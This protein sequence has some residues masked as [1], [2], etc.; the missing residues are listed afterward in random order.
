MR[1]LTCEVTHLRLRHGARLCQN[2]RRVHAVQ[3]FHRMCVKHIFA[4]ERR[5]GG[6]GRGGLR[7]RGGRAGEVSTCGREGRRRRRGAEAGG[8]GEA[9]GPPQL[10]AEKRGGHPRR[11]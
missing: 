3:I 6:G 9:R 7:A 4:P 5:S 8:R 10:A 2:F 11:G 1:P